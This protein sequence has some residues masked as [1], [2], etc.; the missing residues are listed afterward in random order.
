MKIGGLIRQMLITLAGCIIFVIGIEWPAFA[1]NYPVDHDA[2]GDINE[3]SPIWNGYGDWNSYFFHG[4]IES[5][6]HSIP[7]SAPISRF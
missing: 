1:V 2:D 3:A 6:G 5:I 7:A 4:A